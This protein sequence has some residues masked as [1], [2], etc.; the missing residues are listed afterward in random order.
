MSAAS[1]SDV[2]LGVP[3]ASTNTTVSQ[4]YYDYYALQQQQGGEIDAA[5]LFKKG[6][7]RPPKIVIIMRGLPGSGKTY[8][9]NIFKN[10]EI[11]NFH[12]T[13]RIMSIDDYFL[14]EKCVPGEIDPETGKQKINKVL[15]FN[16]D[17]EM[18]EVYSASALKQFERTVRQG[19][20]SF[21]IVDNINNKVKTIEEYWYI[22][23]CAG[24][25]VYVFETPET[26][27]KVCA[28]RN[29]HKRTLAEIEFLK[30]TWEPLPPHFTRLKLGNLLSGEIFS[31]K[32]IN[33]VEMSSE[34][35][36]EETAKT[37][38][39]SNEHN[40]T[41]AST[42][43]SEEATK[44]SWKEEE[45]LSEEN[46]LKRKKKKRL[47][48]DD[49]GD[50]E[51]R[52]PKKPKIEEKTETQS[53]TEIYANRNIQM[54]EKKILRHL[55]ANSEAKTARI[56]KYDKEMAALMGA[57]ATDEQEENKN[58]TEENISIS[59]SNDNSSSNSSLNIITEKSSQ[60]THRHQQR[61]DE[62]SNPQ[63]D[64]DIHQ[65]SESFRAS[66]QEKTLREKKEDKQ[67]TIEAKNPKQTPQIPVYKLMPRKEENVFLKKAREEQLK[68]QKVREAETAI[69]AKL[70]DSKENTK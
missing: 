21:I 53:K 1:P 68:F 5:S 24:Y 12:N 65:P 23:K 36:N 2:S 17:P 34:T 61:A 62:K 60:T 3:A 14:E 59:N 26:D 13:P 15:E 54:E 39:V 31:L 70:S 45:G 66:L 16:Y 52:D 63:R 29:I 44:P 33:D 42:I 28:Q 64:A 51:R 49:E 38:R 43:Q 6:T 27:P 35:Q 11:Q 41:V 25:E 18:V 69:T 8:M 9:A 4:H 48:K 55:E 37:V 67:R 30:Q 10:L 7:P 57:Y 40:G 56:V 58:Q 46:T 50:N 32:E 19:L 47:T 22:A 20:F